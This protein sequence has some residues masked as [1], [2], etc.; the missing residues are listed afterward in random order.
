MEENDVVQFFR[1][2]IYFVVL[3]LLV[4]FGALETAGALLNT[5]NPVVSVVSCSMYPALNVGDILFVYGSSFDDIEE[6]DIV[7]YDVWSEIEFN[8]DGESFHLKESQDQPE[9][10]A[11]TSIGEIRLLEANSRQ[12]PSVARIEIDGDSYIVSPGDI[13]TIDGSRMEVNDVEG[14]DIPIVHRVI[15]K[16]EDYLETKGDNNREQ[17]SFER[18]VRPEQIHGTS[19]FRIPRIGGLKLLASDFLGIEGDEVFRI[20]SY[21]T[22]SQEV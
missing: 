14:M 12:N 15:N 2:N 10:F 3:A 13:V 1:E 4:A 18:E 7:V 16:E 5:E 11:E 6:N 19:F 21:P 17:L 8:I 22:C 9:P 20:D